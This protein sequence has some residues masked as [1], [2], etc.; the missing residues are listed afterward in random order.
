MELNF[1]LGV[2]MIYLIDGTDLFRVDC[3]VL[4]G[5]MIVM[6]LHSR[7]RDREHGRMIEWN[8]DIER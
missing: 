3:L 7:L 2:K 6:D 4:G 5:A 1:L 8:R